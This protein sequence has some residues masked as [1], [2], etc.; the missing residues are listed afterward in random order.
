MRVVLS[1]SDSDKHFQW[2]IKEYEKRLSTKC[3]VQNIKPARSW[4]HEQI[5]QKDTELILSLLQKKYSD[6]YKVLL[7]KDG[8]TMTT[9]Q[10]ADL[11]RKNLNVVF[12][13][14]WPYGLDESLIQK[15]INA[16]ISFGQMTLQHG[17]AKLVLLEQLYRV[18]TIWEGRQYHY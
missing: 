9:E 2:A 12:V 10:F 6:Y 14:G 3:K 17:L 11:L 13:I 4:T 5:I 15:Y 8:K 16:K 1:V 7:S 18:S